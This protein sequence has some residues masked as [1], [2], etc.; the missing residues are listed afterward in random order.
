MARTSLFRFLKRTF[1]QAYQYPHPTKSRFYSSRGSYSRRQFLKFS[2]LVSGG[3]VAASV[4][5][6]L[7]MYGSASPKIAIVGGGIAGLSAAHYLKKAGLVATIYEANSRVGGRI[8]S[9]TGAVSPEL[10]ND[11]GGCFI[12]TDHADMLALIEEFGLGLFNRAED[13]EAAIPETAFWLDGQ[14]YTE[15]EIAEHLRPLAQQI[16]E[17]AALIDADFDRHAPALDQLSVK[18]Y[19]DRHGDKIPVP[20][21]RSLIELSIR[22]EYGVEP[23]ESSALQ[24]LYNLPTVEREQAEV[25]SSDEAFLVEGGSERVIE[26]LASALSGQIQTQKVLTQVQAQGHGFQ[27]T[28]QDTSIVTADFVV[29]AIPFTVL[30]HVDLQVELPETL[31]RFIA[32][33]S[34]GRNEKIFAGFRNR[35]WR[36]AQGFVMDSWSN[37]GFSQIWEDTQRQKDRPEG[38]LTFYL[39]G[40]EVAAVQATPVRQAGQAFVDQL[41]ALLPGA[42]AAVGDRFL[43]T[44][45]T[46][47]PFVRGSYSTFQPGQY[48]EFGEHLYIESDDPEESQDVHVG[49]L[50]FAGEHLSDEFYGYMNGAAQTG[51]LA[52]AV[53]VKR[54]LQS[55]ENQS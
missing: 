54:S 49:N 26:Q 6:N 44:H 8:H 23:E 53:V 19:L 36:Q 16:R 38:V 28:F 27:L 51:R 46:Q 30:R 45:W 42:K 1:K 25:L 21:I 9:V 47:E 50:V 17:D 24:L 35:I 3:V 11:L 12:N 15:A 33:S 39:G 10:V 13:A 31:Q 4:F 14:A 2:T 41:D 52:A 29:L 43:R 22:T 40:N 34:L 48:T 7:K 20:A 32:G 5:P 37:L 18:Q 55:D